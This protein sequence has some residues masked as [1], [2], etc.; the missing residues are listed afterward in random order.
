MLYIESME[1]MNTDRVTCRRCSGTGDSGHY[2][3]NGRCYGCGGKG[4]NSTSES[5]AALALA[6]AREIV[7]R[8]AEVAH[9][10]ENVEKAATGWSRRNAEKNLARSVEM[11]AFW[12][13]QS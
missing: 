3:D 13:A 9:A 7:A 11:L 6:A 2:N 8:R 4:Y 5:N 12:E 10:R 1:N